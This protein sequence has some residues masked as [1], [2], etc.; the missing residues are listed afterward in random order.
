MPNPVGRPKREY[1]PEQ[2]AEIE[3]LAYNNLHDRTIAELVG[4]PKST[5]I[6]NFRTTID[7]KRA[8][9]RR[10]LRLAQNKAAIEDGNITMQI[11][12]GKNDL[13]QTDR[14]EQTITADI[15]MY[16]KDCPIED[17]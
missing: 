4:I 5:L 8:E 17:V 11:F 2:I 9:H 13:E 16:D 7:K 15:K 1:S 14:Q 6:D 10:D 3:R 12:L